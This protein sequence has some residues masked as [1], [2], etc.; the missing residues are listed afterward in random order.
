MS[1]SN[2]LRETLLDEI[3][4]GV[5]Y[6]PALELEIG[7]STSAPN[8]DGTGVTEPADGYD[9]VTVDNDLTTWDNA[10]TVDGGTPDG[11]TSKVND[12]EITFPEATGEWG[13]VTHFVIYDDDDP[14][15]FLGWGELVIPKTIQE[16]DT[17]R[18]AIG[19]LE[20]RLS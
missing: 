16:G 18:F 9:R 11:I 3:F 20:I 4:G 2:F 5:N 14:E 6:T 7:L 1:F 8:D 15:N 13:E 12:I 17:A 10:S 19:D